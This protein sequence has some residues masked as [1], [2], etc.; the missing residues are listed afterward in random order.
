MPLLAGVQ[1]LRPQCVIALLENSHLFRVTDQPPAL[2]AFRVREST[3]LRG[4]QQ[5]QRPIHAR[6]AEYA[7]RFAAEADRDIA[8]LARLVDAAA[9]RLGAGADVSYGHY[10]ERPS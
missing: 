3:P 7:P 9:E 10:L 5:A 6:L 2:L 4:P 1:G 8:R